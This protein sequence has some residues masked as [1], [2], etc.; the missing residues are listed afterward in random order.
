LL[1]IG[2]RDEHKNEEGQKNC[3]GK[4]ARSAHVKVKKGLSSLL[5]SHLMEITNMQVW[6]DH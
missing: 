5:L 4:G 1:I 3:N 2:I 6:L